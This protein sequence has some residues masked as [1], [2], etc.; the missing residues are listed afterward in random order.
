MAAAFIVGIMFIFLQIS[1]GVSADNENSELP[2]ENTEVVN[3]KPANRID[4]VDRA[5]EVKGDFLE[6]T[7]VTHDTTTAI[8]KTKSGDKSK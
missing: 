5:V 3:E 6:I 4:Q 1:T 7:K 2:E 8:L